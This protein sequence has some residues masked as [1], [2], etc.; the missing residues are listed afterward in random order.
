MG[1]Q[2]AVTLAIRK[3]RISRRPDFPTISPDDTRKGFLDP[4]EL[5]AIVAELPEW[6]R[7]VVRVAAITDWRARSEIVQ[8]R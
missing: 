8:M 1:S 7:P 6:W 5:D 3:R 2:A 4:A